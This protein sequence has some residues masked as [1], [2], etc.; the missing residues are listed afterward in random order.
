MTQET[1]AGT[2][3]SGE[4]TAA[5]LQHAAGGEKTYIGEQPEAVQEPQ[6]DENPGD[7]AAAEIEAQAEETPPPKK[8]SVQDR[9]DELTLARREAE[10]RASDLERRLAEVTQPR[11]PQADAPAADAEPDPADFAYGEADPAY[12]RAIAR[13]EGRL[14]YRE[15]AEKHQRETQVRT[16]EQTWAQRQDA[17]AKEHPDFFEKINSDDLAITPVMADAIKTSE[18]GAAVAYHLAT[19]PDEARRIAA[20]NPL[21]QVRELGR[22]EARLAAPQAQTPPAEPAPQPKTVSDAPAP[23]PLARGLRGQFKPP[24]D[25]EDFAAFERSYVRGG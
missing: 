4:D 2:E 22:L 13:Y 1:S 18:D 25:T 17:F 12:I 8:P 7:D 5:V 20:L 16:V 11:Q 10:R 14:A 21:A 3:V 23:A 6:Q 19:N 15:E 9:I 24:A